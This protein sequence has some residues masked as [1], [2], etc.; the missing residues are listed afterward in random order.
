ML[1]DEMDG[2]MRSALLAFYAAAW[3][4]RHTCRRLDKTTTPDELADIIKTCLER[5]WLTYCKHRTTQKERRNGRR[6]P[7]IEV[8]TEC[9]VYRSDGASRRNGRGGSLAGMGAAYWVPGKQEKGPPTERAREYLGT[10]VSN[11]VAE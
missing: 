2:G 4:T 10:G 9:A 3:K 5:P 7:P 8:S 11:N 6:R 1:Q